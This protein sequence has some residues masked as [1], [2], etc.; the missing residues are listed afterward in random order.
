MKRHPA[1]TARRLKFGAA[2][3]ATLLVS[4]AAASPVVF[5]SDP[6]RSLA[7]H[8]DSSCVALGDLDGDGDLDLVFGASDG[9]LS[10]Y[11]DNPG[12]LAGQAPVW[13]GSLAAAPLTGLALGDLDG[14]GDPDLVCCQAGEPPAVLRNRS[15]AFSL[16]AEFLGDGLPA[17]GLVLADLDNDRDLDLVIA[18]DGAPSRRLPNVDGTLR[19]DLA[20]LFDADTTCGAVAAGDLDQDGWLDLVLAGNGSL[21]RVIINRAG[22]LTTDSYTLAAF[23]LGNPTT[24]ALGDIDGDG[25]LDIIV[26]TSTNTIR[27]YLNNGDR[28]FTHFDRSSGPRAA[29]GAALADLDGDGRLD[30]V[31]TTT[32]T[33]APLRW[34]RNSGGAWDT[35]APLG[36]LPPGGLKALA[37]GDLDE[38]GD[39]DVVGATDGSAGEVVLWRR[40]GFLEADASWVE[41]SAGTTYGLAMVDLD[42][43]GDLD[44]VQGLFP[45]PN[46]IRLNQDGSFSAA[47]DQLLTGSWLTTGLVITDWN[48][49]GEPDLLFSNDDPDQP[50]HLHLNQGGN[51]EPAP[52]ALGG[53]GTPAWSLAVADLDN[54]GFDDL[55]TGGTGEL[56]VALRDPTDGGLR[57]NLRLGVGDLSNW[58]NYLAVD[59]VDGDGDPDL[60]AALASGPDVV[61]RNRFNA[62]ATLDTLWISPFAHRTGFVSLQDLDGDAVADLTVGYAEAS[63]DNEWFRGI[64][65]GFDAPGRRWGASA[66]ATWQV[67]MS[68]WDGDG[69]GD[70]LEAEVDGPN[71]LLGNR[72]GYIDQS[73]TPL[74]AAADSARTFR[75]AAG[76][77]DLDGDLDLWVGNSGQPDQ[78]FRGITNPGPSGPAAPAAP[79]LPGTTAYL[80]RL[81]PQPASGNRVLVACEV[82]DRDADPVTIIA[83]CRPAGSPAWFPVETH[84][85]LVG[86]DGGAAHELTFDTA[87]WPDSDRGYVLQLRSVESPRRLAGSR[88][89]PRYEI[90]LPVV[91]IRRPDL[92][93]VRREII[94]PTLTVGGEARSLV[95]VANRGNEALVITGAATSRPTDLSLAL[96]AP[97]EIAPGASLDLELTLA[98]IDTMQHGLLYIMTNDPRAPGDTL[99]VRTDIRSL[100]FAFHFLLEAGATEAPLGASL[101]GLLAPHDGVDMESGRLHYRAAGAVAWKTLELSPLDGDWLGV[102]PGAEV[103]EAGL[104]YYLEARNGRS[105][106]TSPPGAPAAAPRFQAV[107]PPHR[108]GAIVLPHSDAGI[109]ADRDIFIRLVPASGTVFTDGVVQFRRGGE[110]AFQSAPVQADSTARI[111]ATMVGARGLEFHIEAR[112][113]TAQLREPPTG[114]QMIRVQVPALAEPQATEAR[115]Y[116]MVSV[117][118]DF[119]DFT[120]TFGDLVSDQGE[121]GP[122][123]VTRWRCLRYLPESAAYGELSTPG[124]AGAFRPEPGRA[125]WL[126][127]AEANRLDTAPVAGRSLPTGAAWPVELA[128]GWNQIGNPFAFPVAWSD[129]DVADGEG[130]PADTLVTALLAGDGGVI[131]VLPPFGGGWIRNLAPTPLQLR[132]TPREAPPQEAAKPKSGGGWLLRIVTAGVDAGT[133]H[134]RDAAVVV[135]AQAGAREQWDPA[136][137]PAPPSAPDQIFKVSVANLAWS[138]FAGPYVRDIRPPLVQAAGGDATAGHGWDLMVGQTAAAMPAPRDAHLRVEGLETMPDGLRAVLIDRQLRRHVDLT[139]GLRYP[140]V[141][142]GP[143]ADGESG[144]FRL[145]VGT[146]DYIAA[147]LEGAVDT[148]PT[149]TALLP[150]SP[151]PFNPATVLRYE[152]AEAGSVRLCVYDL[153]GHRV[154]ELV[155]A[156]Q[157]AGRYEVLW[158]GRDERGQGLGAGVY[159]ARLDAPGGVVRTMK[160]TLLD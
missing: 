120:G 105:T 82:V 93:I 24:S 137:A 147:A 119:G 134:S 56:R 12:R 83:R 141:V 14:D 33:T 127:A 4:A 58:Y 6:W 136:D 92:E 122:Y 35:P 39:L 13:T 133:G 47:P 94:M 102:I 110:T 29:S 69:Y 51:V 132:F 156:A 151:N 81:L 116:R 160:M 44:V 111:P 34:L 27:T 5:E 28:T 45:G 26:A 79:L 101:T 41:P 55:I 57:E 9:R 31:Y 131:A 16:P 53:P 25:R 152:L 49:D 91:E 48:R 75:L 11:L 149:A 62:G 121:F 157:P 129:V 159:V 8:R 23:Q 2:L 61:F 140:L 18:C 104:E 59:D 148:P 135:G 130:A 71:R 78:I 87:T 38:D 74:W 107:A 43:D 125:Y 139:P 145:E 3:G 90:R 128:P 10:V 73:D 103:T 89:A 36:E 52:T 113:A 60:A 154:R 106:V 22:D 96:P 77:L 142:R 143:A 88:F 63:L 108:L 66:R 117:P 37:L 99:S 150:V 85:D 42:H 46:A 138:R 158:D 112:T 86:A 19:A 21:H 15:G 50:V 40:G 98:P 126:I 68:D 100:D 17:T 144:R 70:L 114:E 115:R 124:L 76:D 54:D 146:A 64:A 155:G 109:L 7:P 30:L 118:L 65:G 123:D 153:R 84:R 95:S 72:A 32:A 1:P 97:R 67:E 80:R 20:V